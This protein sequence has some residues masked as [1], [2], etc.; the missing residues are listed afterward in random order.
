VLENDEVKQLRQ[1]QARERGEGLR[2]ELLEMLRQGPR[3]ATELSPGTPDDVSLSEV[4]FQLERLV[5]EGLVVGSEDGPYR[6][7]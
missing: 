4:F 7:A 5:E 3:S 2:I 6:L 1:R